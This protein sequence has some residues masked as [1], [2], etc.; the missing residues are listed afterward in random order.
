YWADRKLDK[1]G[2]GWVSACLFSRVSA[3]GIAE[4]ISMRG[5]HRGLAVTPDEAA[6]YTLQEGAFYGNL[7]VDDPDPS[8]PPDWNACRGEDKAACMGAGSG[9]VGKRQCPA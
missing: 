3:T 7:F 8:V 1:K 2:K 5:D 4:L 6:D 9:G